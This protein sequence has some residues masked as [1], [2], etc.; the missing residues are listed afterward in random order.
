MHLFGSPT[1]LLG[2]VRGLQIWL[3]WLRYRDHA[4]CRPLVPWCTAGMCRQALEEFVKN[5]PLHSF[6][7]DVEEWWCWSRLRVASKRRLWSIF[8]LKASAPH[9]FSDPKE[10]KCGQLSCGVATCASSAI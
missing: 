4:F 6:H 5:L 8:L 9:G 10:L 7:I 1:V 3:A 2:E